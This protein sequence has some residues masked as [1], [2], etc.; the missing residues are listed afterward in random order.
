VTSAIPQG[1]VL[2]VVLFNT[3]VDDMDS[4]IECT[5]SK[6]SNDIK[7]CG[8]VNILERRDVIQTDLN[9]LERWA[10][11]NLMKFH[12]VKCKVLYM[13]WVIPNTN[14][15]CVENGLRA[16]LKRKTW[17]CWLMRSST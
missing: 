7:M 16:A 2:G 5:L 6:F 9:R 11:A 17:G 14:K 1:S 10:C 12:K 13:G 3:F 8:V 15:G 4:G